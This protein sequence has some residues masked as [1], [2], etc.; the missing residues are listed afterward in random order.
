ML[1]RINMFNNI[2]AVF[3]DMDGTIIDSMWMWEDIDKEFLGKR[4]LTLPRELKEDIEGMSF[5]ETAVYFKNKFNLPE[6]LEEI[7]AIWNNMAL[8]KYKNEVMLKPGVKEF[9]IKLKAKGYKLGIAT[10][11]SMELAKT[12][13]D[14][15]GV[16]KYFDTIITGCDVGAGKPA[17]DIYLKSAELCN[18]S[19]ENCLVFEDVLQGIAAG[20]NAGMKVCAVYDR[21]SEYT[22]D[23]KHQLAD[24]YINDYFEIIDLI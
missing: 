1:D 16:T 9:L 15:R 22:D 8:D 21:Y 7:K 2:N 13:L 19:P 4:N 17:P 14:A 24:Y 18:V 6:G 5:S 3:F 20:H 10:S 23:K 11:N 12:C